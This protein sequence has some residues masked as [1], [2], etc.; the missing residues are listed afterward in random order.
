M[1]TL[2][3]HEKKLTLFLAVAVLA[4]V[5]L[6]GLKVVLS[7]DQ[8]NRREVAQKG[9]E[10]AEARGWMEQKADWEEKAAWLEKNLK[11]VPTENPAPAL[12]KKS[13]SAA[14]AA[15]LKIE[16]QTL[17]APRPGVACTVVSN[18]MRLTGSLGQF[19]LWAGQLY[20]PESGVALTSLNLKLS[21]E[22]PKMVGEAEVG[23]FFRTS[24]E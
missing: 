18:R 12:Q 24:K 14:A 3:R 9:E 21:A 4:G 19:I 5:H 16:E 13:Q 7:W 22:P 1:R 11:T 20:Q 15:G 2:T 10:L 8:A 17:Q 6:L 23:Q